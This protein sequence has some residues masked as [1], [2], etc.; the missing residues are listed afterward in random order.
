VSGSWHTFFLELLTL[1]EACLHSFKM[2]G[3]TYPTRGHYPRRLESY[4]SKCSEP[5]IQWHILE[6]LE[7]LI[8][9]WVSQLNQKE[10][11]QVIAHSP[12]ES[13]VVVRIPVPK[14]TIHNVLYMHSWLHINFTDWWR[15]F[16]YDGPFSQT[17]LCHMATWIITAQPDDHC[18]C[19]SSKTS[20]VSLQKWLQ[21]YL[22][23]FFPG[24]TI[25]ENM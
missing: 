10:A 14:T 12:K 16:F 8:S 19:I 9:D 3:T 1:K 5:I 24:E 4:S 18:K 22:T 6:W 21:D 20:C 23:G 13:N 25:H 7:F 11:R 17:S 2:L 15:M